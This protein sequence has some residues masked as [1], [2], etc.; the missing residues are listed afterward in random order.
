MLRIRSSTQERLVQ[1]RLNVLSLRSKVAPAQYKSPPIGAM[2]I[3]PFKID[4]DFKEGAFNDQNLT[5]K[6]DQ[7]QLVKEW[8]IDHLIAFT[9]TICFALICLYCM[10]HVVVSNLIIFKVLRS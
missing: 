1:Y 8:V 7:G 3:G 10:P 4:L 6:S 9:K 5:F 2:K